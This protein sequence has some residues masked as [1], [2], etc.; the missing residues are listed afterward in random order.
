MKLGRRMRYQWFK[1]IRGGTVPGARIL[2]FSVAAHCLALAILTYLVISRRSA[3]V[4]IFVQRLETAQKI[5]GAAYLPPRAQRSPFQSARKS[6]KRRPAKAQEPQQEFLVEGGVSDAVR[7]EARLGTT[8][9]IN[10]FKFRAIYGFA[11]Y[12]FQLAYQISGTLPVIS[13]AELPPHYEQYVIVEVTIDTDGR[14][15]EARVIS[16]AVNRA[17]QQTLLAAIREF[18]YRPATREGVP[19]PSQADI[20]VHIPT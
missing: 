11:P 2:L 4:I 8:A 15:A 13:A 16:G 10:T 19:I 5:A 20:V 12:N 3:P 6:V 17:I 9:L 14:V 7:E 1:F 18:R